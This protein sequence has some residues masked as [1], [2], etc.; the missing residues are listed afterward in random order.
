MVDS[1][2]DVEVVHKIG[3]LNVEIQN[4]DLLSNEGSLQFQ[5]RLGKNP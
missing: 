5:G 1:T 4:L 3:F 2:T